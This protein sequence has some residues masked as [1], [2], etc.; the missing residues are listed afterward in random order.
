MPL[1]SI[2]ELLCVLA[3]VMLVIAIAS[4]FILVWELKINSPELWISLGRPAIL[5]RDHLMRK[6]PFCG[7][8]RVFWMASGARRLLLAVFWLS[9]STYLVVLIPLVWIWV[10]R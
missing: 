3:V 7:W 8:Q 9:F 5:E 4:R 6:Y 2:F 1:E 10:I